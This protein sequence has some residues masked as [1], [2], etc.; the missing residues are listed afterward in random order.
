L[1]LEFTVFWNDVLERVDSTNKLLQDPTLDLN[2]AV[3]TIKSL[4]SFVQAK[5]DKFNQYEK[6]GA[7]ILETTDYLNNRKRQRNI[8]LNPIDFNETPG[9][10]LA[11]S[12][13][14]KT[15]N[16]LPVISTFICNLDK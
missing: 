11:L 10:E 14:F 16:F 12:Q 7:N 3:S 15:Q 2:I 13:K 1:K 5:R 4:K 6:Q 8:R 9:V